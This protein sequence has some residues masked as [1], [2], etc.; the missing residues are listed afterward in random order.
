MPHSPS[1]VDLSPN[2][3][4]R[5][6]PERRRPLE[7]STSIVFIETLDHSFDPAVDANRPQ[8]L[9]QY[10]SSITRLPPEVLAYIFELYVA[11][12][13][14]LSRPDGVLPQ[15]PFCIAQVCTLWRAVVESDPHLWT[16]IHFH[17]PESRQS[18][19]KDVPMVQ[20]VLDLHLIRSGAL[21]ISLTFTDDRMYLPAKSNLISLLVDRL[22]MHAQRWKCIS[23][24]LAGDYFP[25]LFTFTPCNLSSLECLAINS[26]AVAFAV[27]TMPQLNLESAANLKSFSYTG[28]G[29]SVEDRIHLHWE[30]LA[31]L[32]F[33]FAS[34]F[35]GSFVSRQRLIDLARCRNITTCSLGIDQPP[36]SVVTGSIT[37][38]CL[39]TL[40]VRRVTGPA[41]AHGMIDPLILPQLQNL[42][43]DA[44]N[45]DIGNQ[46]WH[47]RNFSRLLARSGCSLLR[48]SIQDVGFRN[49]ELLRCFSLSPALTS[50]RFIPCPRSQDLSDVIRK[51][52]ASPR[53]RGRRRGHVAL[54]QLREITM[55]SSVERH[56]D[57]ITTM[58]RSRTGACARAAGVATL[59]R[60]EVVF[61]D[62]WHD[63][64]EDG[65]ERVVNSLAQWMY[66]NKSENGREGE[67]EH[68]LEK[69]VVV[70]S[71]YLPVY[72]DV[73]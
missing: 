27:P 40:R 70:D 22:R 15:G 51:L 8:E 3:S 1:A 19:E 57:S 47:N 35:G 65:L 12:S 69:S 41:L 71:P 7:D 25:L 72:I 66:E 62:L 5:L 56:L 50:F 63:R 6:P 26:N 13:K 9:L 48:L 44:S 46:Y 33:E 60:A 54:P 45:L 29:P 53:N 64:S 23:L 59:Q 37:L 31:E 67:D 21:P 73:Q 14:E 30:N 68:L 52:D 43:I 18:R 58:F 24:Q 36:P 42:E 11:F 16:S 20:S 39:Q 34:H 55:A 4:W 38:P 32:S 61:F 10:H 2:D 17:F 49:D 28:P